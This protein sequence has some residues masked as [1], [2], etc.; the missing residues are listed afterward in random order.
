MRRSGAGQTGGLVAGVQ[1]LSPMFG[2]A[3][4]ADLRLALLCS[5][6][7]PLLCTGRVRLLSFFVFQQQGL[8]VFVANEAKP[9]AAAT[10]ALAVDGSVALARPVRQA[11][12]CLSVVTHL[13]SRAC[14]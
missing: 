12:G 4:V 3:S 1:A 2:L 10:F 14:R 6:L 11:P 9:T 8:C 7:R 5:A 13:N